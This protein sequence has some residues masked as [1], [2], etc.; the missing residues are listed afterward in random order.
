M[1]FEERNAQVKSFLGKTVV[2]GMRFTKEEIKTAIHFQEQY[3][4]T[5]VEVL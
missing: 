1:T 2:I 4:D 3:Y 5:E